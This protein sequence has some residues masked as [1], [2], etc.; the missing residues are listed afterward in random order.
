MQ[1]SEG[2]AFNKSSKLVEG[3][4]NLGKYTPEN[5]ANQ[6]GDHALVLMYQPFQGTWYQTLGAFCSKGA[7][8]GEILEKLILEAICLCEKAGFH[9]DGVVSDAGPWNRVMWK[10]FGIHKKKCSCTHP[11]DRQR[12]LFFFSDFPHLMKSIW[13]RIRN[14]QV[15]KVCVIKFWFLSLNKI[16]KVKLNFCLS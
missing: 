1:L 11:V 16:L 13:S 3:L 12:K 2:I 9:V 5:Q 15:I 4:V 14:A 7:A 6:M 8:S 10:L